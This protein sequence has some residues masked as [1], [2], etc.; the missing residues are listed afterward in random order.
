MTADRADERTFLGLPTAPRGVGHLRGDRSFPDAARDALRDGQLRAN[1]GHATSD[2][3]RPS[4]PPSS[5]RCPT[6]QQLREAGRAIKAATMARLDEHLIAL[7]EQVTARGGTVHWAR[8]ANEAN[9]I[10]TGL[11]QATGADE[12]VKVKSM[13]TQE[14]GL[15]EAL[16]AAGIAALRDRPGRADRPARRRRAVSHILV[17]AIHKNR[18]E[19]REIFLRDDARRRPRRSPTTRAGWRWPPARTCASGSCAPGSRSAAPTS[20][21]PR[22][23]RSPSSRARATAGCA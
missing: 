8:D 16:E 20:P 17:P 6:G 15:N 1:L 23:A 3:P 14:I 2:H 9:E 18:A 11:V 22:P 19:I 4:G 5:A 13:A 12:V 10:V 21:S 7:E